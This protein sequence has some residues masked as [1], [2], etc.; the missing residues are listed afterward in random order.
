MRFLDPLRDILPQIESLADPPDQNFIFF[1]S[2]LSRQAKN[3]DE[4]QQVKSKPKRFHSSLHIR[5]AE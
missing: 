5:N 1:K 2:E 4:H 3:G